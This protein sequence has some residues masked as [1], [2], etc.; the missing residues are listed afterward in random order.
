MKFSQHIILSTATIKEALGRLDQ[1]AQD[2]IL[3]VVDEKNILLG[4]VTDGDIRRGFINGISVNE[5][6][7]L[8]AQKEPKY[9]LKDSDEVS[10]LKEY[11]NKN[12][13]IIPIVDPTSK[14]ICDLINFR[15]QKT[16]IPAVAVIM[17]GGEGKRLRPYTETIPKPLLK[18]G[19]KPI[20]E[21]NIDR[22]IN[23]GINDIQISVNYLADQIEQ[24][25][26]NGQMKQ[27]S[28]SYLKETKPLGTIGSIL[29]MNEP[30]YD[31]II[32]MN[33]DLLTNIDFEEFYR[34]YK[35]S[36][37]MM[38]VASTTY[39]V[40]VPYAVLETDKNQFVKSLKEKPRYTYYS[41]AGIY[42]L[43]RQ[44]LD[45][46]PKDTFFDI[47]DLM[48]KIIELDRGIVTFP[49]SGYWLDIGKMEDFEKAQEDIKHL[50][51]D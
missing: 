46:I 24:Y 6:V 7:L 5:K 19:P 29:L 20:I 15:V 47:T 51:L 42:I 48:S 32:V 25:F 49:I 41:N 30:K 40:D 43:N 9:I 50:K 26:G 10:K 33:S 27:I 18:V 17:A 12:L 34:S 11:R 36:G 8:V 16:L 22:L 13:R 23:V 35:N 1:L 14:T 37:A 4:S 44:V 38:A 31:D 2:A 45:L 21:H 3:F 39:H 28:I